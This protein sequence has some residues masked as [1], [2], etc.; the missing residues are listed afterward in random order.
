MQSYRFHKTVDINYCSLLSDQTMTEEKIQNMVKDWS[1]LNE[2]SFVHKYKDEPIP[3]TWMYQF[4]DF[5]RTFQKINTYQFLKYLHSIHYN[6]EPEHIPE[7]MVNM[8]MEESY[9]FLKKLIR[10]IEETIISSI[11]EYKQAEWSK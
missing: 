7:Y 9:K 11:E 8:G 6:I 4:I 5:N 10:D 1:Y 3:E 2:L